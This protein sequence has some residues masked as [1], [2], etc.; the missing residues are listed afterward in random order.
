MSNESSSNIVSD[1]AYKVGVLSTA[2]AGLGIY[3]YS[4]YLQRKSYLVK[5]KAAVTRDIDG[6][7]LD[8]HNY[9]WINGSFSYTTRPWYVRTHQEVVDKL[10]NEYLSQ[11]PLFKD[12]S[13]EHVK[14]EIENVNV[15]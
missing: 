10:W 11:Q 8:P 2:V 13:P 6:V 15:L 3:V 14:I 7:D 1:G 5:W 12:I 4:N 9:D